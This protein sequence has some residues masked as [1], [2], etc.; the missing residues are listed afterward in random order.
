MPPGSS[1]KQKSHKGN[2]SRSS[3]SAVR[4]FLVSICLSPLPLAQYKSTHVCLCLWPGPG[5]TPAHLQTCVLRIQGEGA[6]NVFFHVS[7]SSQPS[8]MVLGQLP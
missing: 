6:S 4:L 3:G 5:P 7:F 1:Q 8:L 2:E